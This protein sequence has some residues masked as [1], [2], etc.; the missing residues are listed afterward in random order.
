MSDSLEQQVVRIVAAAKGLDPSGISP[1]TSMEELGLDSLDGMSI[2][3]DL[4]NEF[5]VEIPDDAAEN[6]RTVGDLIEGVRRLREEP[7]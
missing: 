6:A 5:D 3:F 1:E 7:A 4:E 2:I